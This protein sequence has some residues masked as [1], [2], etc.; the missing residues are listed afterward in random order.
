M[1]MPVVGDVV[2]YVG[3]YV[4]EPH[5]MLGVCFP[6][7]DPP[8]CLVAFVTAVSPIGEVSLSILHGE[9]LTTNTCV[10]ESLEKKPFSWHCKE[11]CQTKVI[12]CNQLHRNNLLTNYLGRV[13]LFLRALKIRKIEK[14]MEELVVV[15]RD[16]MKFTV[17]SVFVGLEVITVLFLIGFIVFQ[18]VKYHNYHQK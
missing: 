3:R 2:H 11:D 18:Q 12:W 5:Y 14:K 17:H 9:E 8:S 13:I 15:V 4:G 10:R 16:S 7:Q 1:G 6:A